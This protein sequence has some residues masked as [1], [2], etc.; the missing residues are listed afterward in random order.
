M[1]KHSV[2]IKESSWIARIAAAKLRC[3]SVAIV[4]GNTIHLNN[5]SKKDFLQNQQWLKHEL[6]HVRQY[7]QHGFLP[8]IIK[9]VWESIKNG[10]YNNRFEAAARAAGEL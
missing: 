7:R 2:F 6:C 8:F 4:I 10:Y 3:N 9:Y 5:S 1:K